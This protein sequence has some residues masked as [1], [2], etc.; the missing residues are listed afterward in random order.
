MRTI[1]TVVRR[2]AGLPPKPYFATK[3]VVI[4]KHTSFGMNVVF[5]CE[6]VRIGDGVGF[7]SNIRVD[8]TTFEIGDYGTVYDFCFFQDRGSSGSGI[9]SGLGRR[10]SSMR[11]AEHRSLTM[12][13][14]VRKANSRDT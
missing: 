5:N 6:R 12:W 2:I 11:R 13:A 10:R 14:S 8:S 7:G 3:D 9:P 1:S 4:G